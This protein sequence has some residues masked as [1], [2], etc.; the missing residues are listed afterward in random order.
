MQTWTWWNLLRYQLCVAFSWFSTANLSP[1]S[2]NVVPDHSRFQ[3]PNACWWFFS[4]LLVHVNKVSLNMACFGFAS[5]CLLHTFWLL[6]AFPACI[7]SWTQNHWIQAQRMKN[8]SNSLELNASSPYL[9]SFLIYSNTQEFKSL[10][11][12]TWMTS[13]TFP[14]RWWR[15]SQKGRPS[16]RRPPSALPGYLT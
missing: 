10:C 14:A 12:F 15:G 3:Q 8:T 7:N 9:P 11:V 5:L 1:N 2:R 4:K 16:K 6:P 13:R